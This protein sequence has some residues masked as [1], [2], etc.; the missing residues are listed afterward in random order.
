MILPAQGICFAIAS[1]TARFV[2]SR[3][4]KDGR[5][6]RSFIGVAGQQTPIPRA[7]ARAYGI[8]AT[9]G[10]LASTVEPG[11]PASAA[12]MKEGD[13]M[14]AFAGVPVSGVDD[15]HRLLT[16]DRIGIVTE[17]SVLRRGGARSSRSRRR[18]HSAMRPRRTAR[19]TAS[20]RLAA[21]SLPPIDA[22]WNFTVWSEMPSRAAIA[23]LDRPSRQE[24]QHVGLPGGQRF[25]RHR[26]VEPGTWRS[27]QDRVRAG[28]DARASR[29]VSYSPSTTIPISSVCVRSSSRSLSVPTSKNSHVGIGGS[30]FTIPPKGGDY[31]TLREAD[32]YRTLGA[33][34]SA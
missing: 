20:V 14:L 4:I 13:V 6:R 32:D 27:D 19:R 15:L 9:S 23:L 26:F 29:S 11:G 28:P 2:A 12:G 30:F 22:T 17:I 31:T 7:L 5:I 10:V 33:N 24:L 34:T 21:P 8:A 25:H 16:E 1:N 18:N 3:L